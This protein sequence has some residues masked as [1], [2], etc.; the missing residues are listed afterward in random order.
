MLHSRSAGQELKA[1]APAASEEEVKTENWRQNNI[2]PVSTSTSENKGWFYFISSL[3]CFIKAAKA[4]SMS[5]NW[6]GFP[7]K[8]Y[9]LFHLLSLLSDWIFMHMQLYWR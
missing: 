9:T 7:K 3:N 4:S 5:L 2:S 8:E 1:A 6:G